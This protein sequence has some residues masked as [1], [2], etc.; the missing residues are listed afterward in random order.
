MAL[1]V[2][3]DFGCRTALEGEGWED[4]VDTLLADKDTA[5]VEFIKK[6]I[7]VL[8]ANKVNVVLVGGTEAWKKVCQEKQAISPERPT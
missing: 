4:V 8:K 2:L 5:Q 3:P 6:I 7:E 1:S